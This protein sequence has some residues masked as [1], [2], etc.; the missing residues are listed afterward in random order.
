MSA[1]H[2]LK[3]WSIQLRI[4]FGK[5]S[6]KIPT[7]E[8]NTSMCV[9]EKQN[10]RRRQAEDA[11]IVQSTSNYQFGGTIT[12]TCTQRICKLPLVLREKTA[13]YSEFINKI[14]CALFF[15][16]ASTNE[17]DGEREERTKNSCA[18]QA[19]AAA[20]QKGKGVKTTYKTTEQ[21]RITEYITC[22][23]CIVH[24]KSGLVTA[25]Q[26]QHT[27]ARAHIIRTHTAWKV[28]RPTESFFSRFSSSRYLHRSVSIQ[29][30]G[31]PSVIGTPTCIGLCV[32][33]CRCNFTV[34]Q[35]AVHS[36]LRERFRTKTYIYHR[37]HMHTYSAHVIQL[38]TMHLHQNQRY[39]R[40]LNGWRLM[41]LLLHFLF[42]LYFPNVL[43]IHC[44]RR[45]CE[46]NSSNYYVRTWKEIYA[47]SIR[48]YMHD[49]D[50]KKNRIKQCYWR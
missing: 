50:N 35:Q 48:I 49:N 13:H 23:T 40:T 3:T 31:K 43:S 36:M 44:A 47:C 38:R 39:R 15:I 29:S 7:N 10:H 4:Q 37:T 12:A 46:K 41:L 27:H 34:E 26:T 20:M 17:N 2:L 21:K 30:Q 8:F 25:I 45:L 9:P 32:S 1:S 24:A 33:V 6:N 42:R 19:V 16:T 18:V 22:N 14:Q 28:I 11:T 5:Q